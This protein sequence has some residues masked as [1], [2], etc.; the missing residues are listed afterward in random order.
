ME[1]AQ[2][3]LNFVRMLTFHVCVVSLRQRFLESPSIRMRSSYIFAEMS[4]RVWTLS[5]IPF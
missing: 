2:H 4:W 5:R 3:A 1:G